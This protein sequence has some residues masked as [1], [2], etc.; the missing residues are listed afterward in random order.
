MN[1]RDLKKHRTVVRVVT[2]SWYDGKGLHTKRSLNVLKK[3]SFG[4]NILKVKS[5]MVCT[6]LLLQI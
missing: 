2:S 3:K 5:K 1:S 6:K 4:F